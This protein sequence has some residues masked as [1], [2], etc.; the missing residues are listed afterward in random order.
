M[1]LAPLENRIPNPAINII[2]STRSKKKG[3]GAVL[4]FDRMKLIEAL[5]KDECKM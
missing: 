4:T 3:N 5:I 1:A 2:Y